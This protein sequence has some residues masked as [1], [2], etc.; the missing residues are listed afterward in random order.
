MKTFARLGML[1]LAVS[2]FTGCN[3]SPEAASN[4]D[5][6]GDRITAQA[7][8]DDMSPELKTIAHTPEQHLNYGARSVDTTGRQIWGDWDRIWFLDRPMRLTPYPIP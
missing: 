4:P 6:D 1:L 2:M 3:N 5:P 7:V 8:R